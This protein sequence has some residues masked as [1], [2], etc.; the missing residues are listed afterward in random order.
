MKIS[1][2]DAP[3]YADPFGL[4]VGIPPK[5]LANRSPEVPLNQV[6]VRW[7][8]SRTLSAVSVRKPFRARHIR[9][10]VPPCLGMALA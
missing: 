7:G 8:S 9:K 10:R 4:A 5:W 1:A 3:G 6:I 2:S